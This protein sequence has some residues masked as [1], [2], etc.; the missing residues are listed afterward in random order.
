MT[1]IFDGHRTS[2]GVLYN[3]TLTQRQ[4]ESL[5][6]W[7]AGF[8]NI[9]ALCR[10][11][12]VCVWEQQTKSRAECVCVCVCVRESVLKPVCV[13][14]H[15]W[16]AGLRHCFDCVCE[17]LCAVCERM[18]LISNTKLFFFHLF[19]LVWIVNEPLII[20]YLVAIILLDTVCTWVS[21]L[22]LCVCMEVWD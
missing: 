9:H 14:Q 8:L 4:N 2:E 18:C 22:M 19:F 20:Q 5:S 7:K 3:V 11:L 13:H 16:L 12:T 10:M 6:S 17:S 21:P 1:E 15:S